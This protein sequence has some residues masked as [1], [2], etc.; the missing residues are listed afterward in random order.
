MMEV[1]RGDI[2]LADLNPIIGSEQGG[3]RPVIVVQ[4]DVGNKYSPT[5]IVIAV[6]SRVYKKDLPVHVALKSECL[7]KKSMALLE[8]VRTIDK[9]R[10]KEYLGRVSKR[11]MNEIER[12]LYVSF[13]I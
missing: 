2:Y 4:N 3:E 11:E 1:K 6:S 10:L 12:A 8:Q 13:D 9:S 7:P 5:I